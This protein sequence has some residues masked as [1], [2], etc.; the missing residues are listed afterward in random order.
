[1]G[2]LLVVNEMIF[3]KFAARLPGAASN[4]NPQKAA[5]SARSTVR[6]KMYNGWRKCSLIGVDR[7]VDSMGL[8]QA[9][10]GGLRTDSWVALA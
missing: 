5:A 9:K 8:S 10:V 7:L 2:A 6:G 4:A 1:M 3:V